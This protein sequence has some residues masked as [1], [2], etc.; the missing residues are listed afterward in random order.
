MHID[1][2]E[3]FHV[4]LPLIAPVATPWGDRDRLETVLVRIDSGS[5]SGWGEASPGSGPFSGPEWAGGVFACARDWLGPRLVGEEVGSGQ[6][7]QERLAAVRGNRFA[8]AALDT[9]WWDLS[10]RLS[11]RPLHHCLG[12]ERDRIEVGASFDRME[13]FDEFL[14]SIGGAF[15]AGFAR[16]ELKFRPGWDVQMLAAVRRVFPIER[17]HIDCEAGLRL[18]HM[19]MLCRLDDFCLAMVEQPLSADDLVGHAM[20]QEAVKTPISLDESITSLDQAELALELQSGKYINLKPGR[21]GGLTPAIAIHDACHEQCVACWVGAMPQS[22]IG[23]RL[24]AALATKSNCTYPA[25][26]FPSEKV[27]RADLAEPLATVRDADGVLRVPLWTAPGIG[28]EP[29]AKRLGELTLAKAM[30]RC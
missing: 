29:D 23:A 14:E 6:A 26:L 17:I 3:L 5:V 10:S 7:L 9:A 16:V 2:I 28:I 19:E 20:V 15:A 8:K 4:G 1:S 12:G 18:D 22:A 21:V 27:L 25:D 13:S 24:G 11:E 30:L